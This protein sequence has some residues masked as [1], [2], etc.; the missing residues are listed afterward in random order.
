MSSSKA[1]AT[2]FLDDTEEILRKKIMT[3]CLSGADPDPEVHKKKGGNVDMDI[4]Y[5]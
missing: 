1:D 3:L 5:Q 4:A 2:L